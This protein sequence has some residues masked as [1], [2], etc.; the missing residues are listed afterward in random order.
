M[1]YI[2]SCLG[3]T[4]PCKGPPPESKSVLPSP[5]LDRI[6][7]QMIHTDDQILDLIEDLR[8]VG[9]SQTP[10]EELQRLLGEWERDVNIDSIRGRSPEEIQVLQTNLQLVPDG[11]FGRK[12]QETLARWSLP[13][14]YS[15][16]KDKG[17]EVKVLESLQA[18]P[19]SRRFMVV[20]KG[21]GVCFGTKTVYPCSPQD[22]EGA[23]LYWSITEDI[24]TGALFWG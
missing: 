6:F 8:S 1:T 5:P 10:R 24:P 7:R 17:K 12:T 3:Q 21:F 22:L 16:M 11:I 4:G 20:Y 13:S 23:L 2:S 14:F 9:Q 19:L 18:P 15:W